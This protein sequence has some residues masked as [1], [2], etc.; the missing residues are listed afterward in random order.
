M[1]VLSIYRSRPEEDMK[2]LTDSV[3]GSGE[4]TEVMLY[5]MNE[6]N[7]DELLELIFASDKV[8]SWW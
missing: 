7:Y 6:V 8:Y 2:S 5:E 1:K 3:V 4:V